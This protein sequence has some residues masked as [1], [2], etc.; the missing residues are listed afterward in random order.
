MVRLDIAP[1]PPSQRQ[2][3]TLGR[4]GVEVEEVEV[5]RRRGPGPGPELK[6][7]AHQLE[8]GQK[9]TA[10]VSKGLKHVLFL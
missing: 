7:G 1:V 10:T 6:A 9:V 8:L 2:R 5:E 3:T 4:W